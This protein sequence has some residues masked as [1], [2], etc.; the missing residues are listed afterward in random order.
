[1]IIDRAGKSLSTGRKAELEK[2]KRILQARV[3]GKGDA[4]RPG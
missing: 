4:A 3:H 1:L 2:A